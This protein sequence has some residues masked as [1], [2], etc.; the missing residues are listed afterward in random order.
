[1]DLL[2]CEICAKHFAAD[3]LTTDLVEL[4]KDGQAAIYCSHFCKCQVKKKRQRHKYR[5]QLC[6]SDSI[7][8]GSKAERAYYHRLKALQ[9]NGEVI[10]FLRQVPFDLPG[11][12]KYFVDFQVFYADCSV[13][14]VDVKGMSTPLFIMKK[15]QVEELYPI[16]IEVVKC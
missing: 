15:K 4:N 10:F 2:Q 3:T 8:F 12:V 7:K 5:A 11:N 1:M 16:N 13:A 9:K 14:F 6:E